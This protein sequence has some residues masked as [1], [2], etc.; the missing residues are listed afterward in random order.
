MSPVITSSA[1][2]W[3]AVQAEPGQEVDHH[4]AAADLRAD[5]LGRGAIA[6][7]L[8]VRNAD[9]PGREQRLERLDRIAFGVRHRVHAAARGHHL[10]ERVDEREHP[11]AAHHELI[12]RIERR[13]VDVVRLRE[14]QHLDVVVDVLL[15]AAQEAHVEELIH[16]FEHVPWLDT[17]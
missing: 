3:S 6:D 12:D 5:A 4:L 2:R 1:L 7:H 11:A 13:R 15:L 14:H 9:P 8:T 10:G 16:R 17:D